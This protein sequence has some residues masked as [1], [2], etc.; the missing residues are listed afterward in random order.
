MSK[1]AVHIAHYKKGA[2]G[3][4]ASHSWYKR[5]EEDSHSN[6]DID[7]SR[8]K[9][10]IALVLPEQGLYREVKSLVEQSTGRVTSASVWVS[11][12]IVYPPEQLQDPLT[13]DKEELQRY[14][15]DVLAW[16]NER[17]K[18]PMA[19]VHLDETTA[20]MHVDTVPITKDGRLS[21]KDVYTRAALNNI[22]TEL[23][24]YLAERG[25]DIQ[26]G[27]STKGKQVRSQT[28]P[29][30]KR[31]AEEQKLQL[32]GEIEEM[33]ET[34]SMLQ[35]EIEQAEERLQEISDWPAYES[36]ANR[37]WNILESF[38]K[39]MQ[40]VFNS[41]WVFRNRK[42]ERGLLGAIE[43]VRDAIMA[44]ISA[45]RGFEKS[46]RVPE[47]HQRSKVIMKSLDGLIQDA[48]DRG[49]SP[50]PKRLNGK[51]EIDR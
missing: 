2:V 4:L 17:F 19:V 10:N 16:M 34:K 36:E 13:A 21:R 31:Q 51:D 5:D 33:K 3:S 30:Y 38:K 35:N 15:G 7:T 48:H 12:W 22:H 39:L 6:Q 11:E 18:V 37:A 43:N 29:E 27:E 44:S 41:G 23:A 14:F 46:Q 28:V 1:L 32:V 25:W 45:L 20:H 40:D 8:S 9:D 26:R 50:A 49:A 47:D 42:A 24:D